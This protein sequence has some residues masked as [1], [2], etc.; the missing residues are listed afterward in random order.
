MNAKSIIMALV[1]MLTMSTT[2]FAQTSFGKYPYSTMKKVFYLLLLA[3]LTVSCNS[4][5]MRSQAS[6]DSLFPI[7]EFSELTPEQIYPDIM[8]KNPAGLLLVRN[9]LIINDLQ[10]DSLIFVLD[11]EKE[12]AIKRLAPVGQG[13]FDFLGINDMHFD[14]KEL[15]I[16]DY[17][18]RSYSYYSIK[19]DNINLDEESLTH[20]DSFR[21][22]GSPF[23]D[24]YIRSGT[25]DRN[26]MMQISSKGDTIN[27][28]APYPGDTLG[29]S[30]PYFIMRKGYTYITS[31]DKNRVVVAGNT[32]DWLCF[33]KNEKGEPKSTK[34][35]FSFETERIFEA[36]YDGD[37]L[38]SFSINNSPST[39]LTYRDMYATENQ[40][41]ALYY[42]FAAESLDNPDNTCYI[43]QF[44]WEGNYQKAYHLQEVISHFAVDEERGCI[45]ATYTPKGEDPELLKYKL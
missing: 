43:L 35:Y 5:F 9:W 42:G 28:F 11:M 39:L 24:G 7:K 27:Y 21:G 3:A 6:E 25:Q 19:S 2:L 13:P 1:L 45:Y 14:G 4:P 17:R 16:H 34:E 8:L 32:S 15:G 23:A 20:K 29:I 44:D 41:Y 12:G 40:F 33:F 22:M 10:Q 37:R 26:L 18:K 36:Q 30:Q 38:R 31:P